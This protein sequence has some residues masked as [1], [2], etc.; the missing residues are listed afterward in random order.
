VLTVSP[1]VVE[2]TFVPGAA[3]LQHQGGGFD[4][5]SASASR[6]T[7]PRRSKPAPP[8]ARFAT[9]QTFVVD[10]GRSL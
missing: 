4:R 7:L 6:T 8:R 10:G 1:G 2:S 5:S 9:G 3:R